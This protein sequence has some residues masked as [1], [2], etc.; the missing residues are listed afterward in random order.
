MLSSVS[1]RSGWRRSNFEDTYCLLK[2]LRWIPAKSRIFW[3]GNRQPLYI[4]SEVSL[5]WLV[6][7]ADLF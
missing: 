6:I 4:K 1:A 7:T 5:D 2:G 3:S